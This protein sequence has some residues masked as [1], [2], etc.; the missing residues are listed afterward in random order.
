MTELVVTNMEGGDPTVGDRSPVL[1]NLRELEI[2]LVNYPHD[3]EF[4]IIF[5]IDVDVVSDSKVKIYWETDEPATTQLEYGKT[6]LLEEVY[7]KTTLTTSH[8]ATLIGLESRTIYFFRVISKDSAGNTAVDDN[9]GEFYTFE[10]LEEVVPETET[11][12]KTRPAFRSPGF[13]LIIVVS[14][15]L[16]S[17]IAIYLQ[18]LKN[19]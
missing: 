9:N 8:T 6:P 16:H 4:P 15:L 13:S 17:G 10:T 5:N 18:K 1:T 3:T 14:F 11:S 12:G 2:E 19:K 7:E